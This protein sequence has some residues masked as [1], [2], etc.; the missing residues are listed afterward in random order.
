MLAELRR[1]KEEVVDL[2][3]SQGPHKAT[4][5]LVPQPPKTAVSVALHGDEGESRRSRDGMS[6]GEASSAQPLDYLEDGGDRESESLIQV[7]IFSVHC[8]YCRLANP[9]PKAMHSQKDATVLFE[10]HHVQGTCLCNRSGTGV[11]QASGY[12]VQS[13]LFEFVVVRF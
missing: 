10:S 1:K 9:H 5:E 11:H 12:G 2:E 4:V 6:G 8:C 7:G 3:A 13:A